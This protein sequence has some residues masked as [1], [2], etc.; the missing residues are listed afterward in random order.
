MQTIELGYRKEEKQGYLVL[1]AVV[2]GVNR[3]TF[4][5]VMC[6]YVLCRSLLKVDKCHPTLYTLHMNLYRDIHP[7]AFD[8]AAQCH[9]DIKAAAFIKYKYCLLNS[10]SFT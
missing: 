2:Y 5:P 8:T 9:S 6:Y 1:H 10:S 7:A 3:V 4:D